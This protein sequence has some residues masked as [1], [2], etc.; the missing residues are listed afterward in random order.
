MELFISYCM[1]HLIFRNKIV[2]TKLRVAVTPDVAG[3]IVFVD[4]ITSISAGYQ[5]R[6]GRVRTVIAQVL[7]A[8]C[9]I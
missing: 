4:V 5:V 7:D 6:V 2:V 3:M 1:Y 9:P 8:G